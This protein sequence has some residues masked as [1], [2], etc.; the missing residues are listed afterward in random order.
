MG[1]RQFVVQ[2][3]LDTT[4]WAAVVGG[5]V[6]PHA[7]RQV[8][9]PAGRGHHDST[10]P[11]SEVGGRSGTGSEPPARFDD[12]VDIVVR[13]RDLS[14]FE[15]SGDGYVLPVEPQALFGRLD[16]G[17]QHPGNGTVFEQEGERLGVRVWLVHRDDLDAGGRR[18]VEQDP[19]EG[20]ADAAEAVDAHMYC[21][22][23]SL[24]RGVH[25]SVGSSASES[26]R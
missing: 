26:M 6:H 11:G 4:V 13:P 14:G 8:D 20:S 16:R 7:D 10:R 12:Y 23:F 1:A 21:H 25:A 18:A 5:V 17:C 3:A 9:V 24:A 15:V 22:G 2:D 19:L